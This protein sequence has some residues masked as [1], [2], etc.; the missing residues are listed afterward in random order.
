VTIVKSSED[1][2]TIKKT[3]G[4]EKSLDVWEKLY[5]L[6]RF[7]AKF[8]QSRLADDEH[9]LRKVVGKPRAG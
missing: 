5:Q 8:P 9:T 3:V 4:Q 1:G 6:N 7:V 2:E